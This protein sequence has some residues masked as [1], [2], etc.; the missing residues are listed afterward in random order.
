MSSHSWRA[1]SKLRARSRKEVMEGEVFVLFATEVFDMACA[2]RSNARR[3]YLTS[4]PG[5][6]ILGVAYFVQLTATGLS[7]ASLDPRTGCAG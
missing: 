7:F 4:F 1:P 3:P 5:T 2:L 6:D